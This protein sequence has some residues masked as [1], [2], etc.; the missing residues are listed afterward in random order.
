MICRSNSCSI[1][2]LEGTMK[3][4]LVALIVSLAMGAATISV[5]GQ[6]GGVVNGAKQ[7]GEATKE[8]AKAA[9]EATK[10]GVKTAGEATKE[11]AKKTT[12]VVTGKAHANCADGTTQTAK[13]ARAAS[14]AC[15][16]HGGVAK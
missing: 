6:L 11:G 1:F 8:G 14:A 16:K 4:T 3:R 9:G 7:A 10:E 5:A 2:V 13:T 12:E 15:A